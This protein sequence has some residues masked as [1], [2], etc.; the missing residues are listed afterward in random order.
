MYV[1]KIQSESLVWIS[2]VLDTSQES[3]S[4]LVGLFEF[5]VCLHLSAAVVMLMQ[6]IGI[7]LLKR[8]YSILLSYTLWKQY[9][10]Y[11]SV[12]YC[13][14]IFHLNVQYLAVHV[15]RLSKYLS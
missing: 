13:M 5:T 6:S 4:M 14:C 1:I 8:N 3:T 11:D 7:E 12:N 10:H 9:N 15:T 2:Q